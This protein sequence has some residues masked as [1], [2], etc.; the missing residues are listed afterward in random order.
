M[1]PAEKGRHCAA[2]QKTVVDFT[3]MSDTEIIRYMSQAGHN[4]CGRLTSHQINRPLVP[5]TPPQKN[6][7]PAWPLLLTS[8][9]LTHDESQYRRQPIPQEQQDR[10]PPQIDD[11]FT[12]LGTTLSNIIPDTA[13]VDTIFAPELTMGDIVLAPPNDLVPSDSTKPD[14]STCAKTEPPL[15]MGKPDLIPIKLD[16]PIQ[17]I[18]DTVKKIITDT[19]SI[20][21]QKQFLPDQLL[22]PAFT[23]Y[24]NPIRRGSAFHIS[25]QAGPGRYQVSLFSSSGALIQ[26]TTLDI[27]DKQQIGEWQLPTNQPTG[28]YIL[29]AVQQGRNNVYAREVAVQ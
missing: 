3:A 14:T 17:T 24:P 10:K 15:V 26:A 22:P 19:F 21:P 28:I 8:L 25:W 1:Q 16:S 6:K 18:I 20:L 27:T 7:L 23:V 9:L 5:L 11:N 29:R 12:I 4:V 2:C 13:V